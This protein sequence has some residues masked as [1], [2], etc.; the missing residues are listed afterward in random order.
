MTTAVQTPVQSEY[1]NLPLE[2]LTE[3]PLNPRRTFDDAALQEL[4]ESIRTQGVLSPLLVRPKGPQ[5]YEI[6]A[7]ARRWVSLLNYALAPVVAFERRV[8]SE[9]DVGHS[10]QC[11]EAIFNLTIEPRNPVDGVA[12]AFRIE[13]KHVAIC[14]LYAE[15]LILQIRK[16]LGHQNGSGNEDQGQSRLENDE[17]LLRK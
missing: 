16:R 4:A 9:A 13:V 2:S 10:R 6:V 14:G 8:E 3:S 5:T 11:R 17:S 1:R 15:F 7:G 12:R